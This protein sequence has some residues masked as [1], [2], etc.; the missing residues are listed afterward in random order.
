MSVSEFLHDKSQ[1]VEAALE[2][3]L[4]ECDKVPSALMEAMRYS[5]L[6]GG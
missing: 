2:A 4:N 6:G 3:A 5:L 1:Q